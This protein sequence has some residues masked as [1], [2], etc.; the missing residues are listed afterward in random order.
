[1]SFAVKRMISEKRKRETCS[2]QTFG[3]RLIYICGAR[4]LSYN[5]ALETI[6][7]SFMPL[8]PSNLR[9]FGAPP[10]IGR[11][12]C[13]REPLPLEGAAERSEARLASFLGDEAASS[14]PSPWGKALPGKRYSRFF[15]HPTQKR[16]S[17]TSGRF[18]VYYLL[19]AK[20]FQAVDGKS[21]IDGTAMCGSPMDLFLVSSINNSPFFIPIKKSRTRKEHLRLQNL[22]RWPCEICWNQVSTDLS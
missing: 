15:I 19:L 1:M 17:L 5:G 12:E 2:P 13:P 9:P 10:S 16:P 14:L 11:R 20:L 7:L 18:Y 3:H 21:C 8:S 4:V 6:S 22:H